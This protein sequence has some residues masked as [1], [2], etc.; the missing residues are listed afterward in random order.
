S[1]R[2]V[3]VKRGAREPVAILGHRKLIRRHPVLKFLAFAVGVPE[4][5]PVRQGDMTGQHCICQHDYTLGA[6][7]LRYDPHAA[8]ALDSKCAAVRRVHPERARW[9]LRT[10]LRIAD[11]GVRGRRAPLACG[12]YERELGVARRMLLAK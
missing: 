8:T 12:E 2:H 6:R 1:R 10:P 3:L 9:I 11:D 7:T 4:A 5:G